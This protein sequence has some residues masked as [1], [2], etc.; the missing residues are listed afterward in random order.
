M[1]C[2]TDAYCIQSPFATLDAGATMP[3]DATAADAPADGKSD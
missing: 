2:G 1:V 3:G